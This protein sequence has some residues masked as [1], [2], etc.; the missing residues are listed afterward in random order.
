MLEKD[1]AENKLTYNQKNCLIYR[2]GEKKLF[3]SH[4]EFISQILNLFDMPLKDARKFIE[5]NR[6]QFQYVTGY[7]KDNIFPLLV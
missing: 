6:V 4:I 7:V 3:T 2:L 1:D 5:K